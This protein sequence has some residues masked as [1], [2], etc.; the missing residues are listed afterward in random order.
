MGYDVARFVKAVDE[1]FVCA[2]CSGVIDDAVLGCQHGHAFC[3]ACLQTWRDKKGT[4]CPLCA[5]DIS[6]WH[7]TPCLPLQNMIRALT[8]RCGRV[9]DGDADATGKKV[10]CPYEGS[11]DNLLLHDRDCIFIVV[12]CRFPG[13]THRCT[14]RRMEAH[15]AACTHRPAKCPKCGIELRPADLPRHLADECPEEPVPCLLHACGCQVR[16]KRREQLAHQAEYAEEHAKLVTQQRV[17]LEAVESCLDAHGSWIPDEGQ[18]VNLLSRIHERATADGDAARDELT[19]SGAVQLVV[20]LLVS[21]RAS[22]TVQ[23]A[24]L[25]ALNAICSAEGGSVMVD[26]ATIGCV[27]SGGAALLAG[28]PGLLPSGGAENRISPRPPTISRLAA[29]ASKAGLPSPPHS[30]LLKAALAV[31][32]PPSTAATEADRLMLDPPSTAMAGGGIVDSTSIRLQCVADA[33][34]LEASVGALVAHSSDPQVQKVCCEVVAAL[35]GGNDAGGAASRRARAVAAGTIERVTHALRSFH[36]DAGVLYAAASV[37]RNICAGEDEDAGE[38][39]VQ[40]AEVGAIEA[41]CLALTAHPKDGRLHEV[42]CRTM[43][44]LC[45]GGDA[46]GRARK[47]R[48]TDA[49]AIDVACNAY[50]VFSYDSLACREAVRMLIAL[51]AGLDSFGK[52][53]QQRATDAGALRVVVTALLSTS[54]GSETTKF[55]AGR[56]RALRNLTRNHEVL[57][58]AAKDLGAKPE[59]L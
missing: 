7:A 40:T 44:A 42:C 31:K 28:I 34:A 43:T 52:A 20:G 49:G 58:Q 29:A 36:S 2:I 41:L 22:T 8:V 25:G 12:Q 21:R 37:L 27:T 5:I 1:N 15:A 45:Y 46:S 56:Y 13:C 53:R 59:W 19:S 38:R 39:R 51:L 24:G 9:D 54:N 50:H 26:H 17:R 35:C 6:Q 48:A 55:K 32:Q 4:T 30:R 18:A 14:R 33:G 16:P 23:I 57:Q 10:A 47:L 3:S 11:L